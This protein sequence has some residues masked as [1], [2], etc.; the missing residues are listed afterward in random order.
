MKCQWSGRPEVWFSSRRMVAPLASPASPVSFAAP[1]Y[2]FAGASSFNFPC[3]TSAMMAV[4]VKGLLIDNGAYEVAKV[5]VHVGA[6]G[7]GLEVGND[8]TVTCF[9]QAI[10]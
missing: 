5:A 4:A 9:A 1:R 8:S 10:E 7:G 6:D 3:L 2:S